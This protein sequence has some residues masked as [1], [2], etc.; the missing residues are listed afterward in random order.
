MAIKWGMTGK[1]PMDHLYN[2]NGGWSF[3]RGKQENSIVSNTKGIGDTKEEASHSTSLSTDNQWHHIVSTYDGGTRKI[4]LDGTEVSSESAS[5]AVASTAAS[6]LLGASDMNNTAST[7]AAARHS[8]IKLDEVRFYSRGLTS[9]QVSALY[10]FG[11]GDIGNIGDFATLPSKISGT[12]GTALST[13][14]T[15]GFPNPYYEAV[16]LTP[17]Y[18][19]IIQPEKSPVLLLWE[20]SVQSP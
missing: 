3:G 20:E 18:R 16:N 17:D 9:T 11:K 5:G 6:L 4:Y 12:T 7:I 15:A 13:T 10:N 19:L 1:L 14:I 2:T 8:G